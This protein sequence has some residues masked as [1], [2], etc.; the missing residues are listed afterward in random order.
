MN[1]MVINVFEK[2]F[3]VVEVLISANIIKAPLGININSG[4]KKTSGRYF[5]E[6]FKF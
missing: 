4:N 3:I 6:V 2:E 5:P 1:S